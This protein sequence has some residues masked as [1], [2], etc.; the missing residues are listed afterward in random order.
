MLQAEAA[1]CGLACL[2]MIARHHGHDVDLPGLRRRFSM[3]LKGANLARVMAVATDLGFTTR[4]LRLDLDEL[5]QLKVPC[6]LHWDLNHFVVLKHVGAHHLIVHDPA[7]GVRKIRL[8]EV[9]KRFTGVALELTPSVD[10]KPVKAREK[11]SVRALVGSVHGVAP[12]LVQILLLALALEVFSLVGPFYM[13][14]V[15]D[16]VLVSADH[17]LLMLLGVGFLAIVV[18]QTLT[19]ALQSWVVTCFGTNL[20]LQ[21]V[22]NLFGHMLNL[23]LDW[24]EKRH[25]GDIT[26]RFGSIGVIQSTLTTDFLGALLDGLMS[27]VTLAVICFYSLPLTALTAGLFLAYLGLRLAFFRPLY[28]LTEEQIICS[29]KQST[30]MLE[31][32]RGALPIKLGNKQVVRRASYANAMVETTNRALATQRLGILFKGLNSL[33]FGAGHVVLI[34]LAALQVLDGHFTVGML[35]AFVSYSGQFGSRAGGLVDYAMKVRML[36]L[37]AERVADIALTEPEK[38]EWRAG[39]LSAAGVGN[40]PLEVRN[41]SFRYAEG[42]PWVLRDCSLRVEPGEWVA[43]VGSSGGGKTT[44]AKIILGLLKPAQGEVLYGGRTLEQIGLARYREQIGAVMQEDR[45]FAGSIAENISFFD[46]QADPR[47]IVS[48]ARM[49]A[50]HADIEAMLMGY[51]SLVGDMGSSLS[52]GQKQRV[53][54]ARALYRQPTLLVLDEAT[55]H[56]DDACEQQVNEAVAHLEAT[57][58]VIAHRKETIMQADRVLRCTNGTVTPVA[59]A[60]P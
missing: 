49:A 6:I 24:Y 60:A 34:W 26:S 43:I 54:L 17:S 8:S 52:G 40:L 46:P 32:I 11:I 4:P 20:S 21:W 19:S 42:E 47:R 55:S 28:R 12:A 9:S 25:I 37:H 58:V 53:I 10:F 13:Q 18:F 39:N 30:A 31:S 27:F 45:L 2:A 16:D 51:E 36:R 5:A 1:E 22:N 44:L 33:L 29:A 23:P 7:H 35:V 38:T 57:R 41:V 56:L 50:I 3:S 59:E 15:I 14:F 48:A